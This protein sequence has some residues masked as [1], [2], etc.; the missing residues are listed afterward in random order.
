M[1]E[2]LSLVLLHHVEVVHGGTG[3]RYADV[4]A[5]LVEPAWPHWRLRQ[6]GADVVLS[7]DAARAPA[8]PA[9][10]D[11][12]VRVADDALRGRFTGGG[13][14]RI[15]LAQGGDANRSL[16]LPVQDVQLEVTLV[17]A[18]GDPRP[19]RT[20]QARLNGTTVPLPAI[21]AGSNVYRSALRS[22]DPAFQPFG[23]F[24]NGTR[25]ASASLDYTRPVTR[26]R[27]IDP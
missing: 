16:T 1:S 25:K 5:R 7:A 10:T 3:K 12:E 23:V 18:N 24:V 20:V 9:T 8:E 15:T 13:V 2:T 14:A 27:V 11:L 26:I 21:A 22:W 19:G 4:E 17:R 6:R